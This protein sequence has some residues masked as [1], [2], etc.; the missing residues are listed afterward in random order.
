MLAISKRHH[1]QKQK[2]G[3]AIK[4]QKKGKATHSTQVKR[5]STLKTTISKA[6]LLNFEGWNQIKKK[7]YSQYVPEHTL[8]V[9]N[10][11]RVL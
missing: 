6:A 10:S 11:S 7:S 8:V 9:D 3:S 5:G 2:I 4:A 1:P